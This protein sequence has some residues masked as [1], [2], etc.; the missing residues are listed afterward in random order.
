MEVALLFTDIEGSTR[1]LERNATAY[2]C[3]LARHL[4]ILRSLATEYGGREFQDA[5]DGLLLAFPAP[6]DAARAAHAMQDGLSAALWPEEIGAPRVRMAVHWAEAEFRDGQYRGAAIHAASRILGAAH[7]GQILCSEAAA[8]A[9]DGKLPLRRLGA[10]RLRGFDEALTLFQLAP[11][12]VFPPLRAKFARRHNL[13]PSQD[14]FIGRAS[15]KRDLAEAVRPGCGARLITLT[16][17]GGIGKTRLALE[18]ASE[19]LEAYEHGVLHVALSG[20]IH[21]EEIFDAILKALERDPGGEER[22]AGQVVKAL[23]GLPTLLVFDNCEQLSAEGA[24]AVGFLLKELPE[25][26][27]LATSRTQIGIPGEVD[28]SVGPLDV[29][30]EGET[31]PGEIARYETVRLFLHRTARLRVDVP[32]DADRAVC[33]ARICRALDGLPLAVELAA[34]RIQVLTVEEL[35]EELRDGGSGPGRGQGPGSRSGLRLAFDWSVRMLP[36]DAASVLGSLGVFCGGWTVRTASQVCA[37]EGA[38]HVRAYLHYLLT[39]SLIRATEHGGVMRFVMLEPIRQLCREYFPAIWQEAEG[40]HRIYFRK[41]ASRL[42]AAIGTSEESVLIDE[43]EPEI[44]NILAAIEREPSNQERLFSAVDFHEFAFNRSCNRRLRVLLTSLRQEGGE[45]QL[46]TLARA[47]NAAGALDQGVAELDAAEEAYRRAAELFQ[48]NGEEQGAM[49]ARFNMATLAFER[50][51]DQEA[52]EIF[53]ATLGVLR[54]KGAHRACIKTLLNLAITALH[55]E[56]LS[57]AH[58]FVRESRA[59][60]EEDGDTGEL[61]EVLQ[62][63]GEVEIALGDLQGAR[64]H[65]VRSFRINLRLGR[66]LVLPELLCSLARLGR[67]SLDWP[68]CAFFCGATHAASGRFQAPLSN[69]SSALMEKT[70]AV[71]RN[72]LERGIFHREFLRGESASPE[73]WLEAAEQHVGGLENDKLLD[74]VA[75]VSL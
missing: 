30:P 38:S 3:L 41:L 21:S 27:I 5:G 32:L 70:L 71:C 68:G 14:A 59:L 63:S 52:F 72:R 67:S 53:S 44:A 37:A 8:T 58:E 74:P 33:I 56:R 35:A 62:V 31:R 9:L 61:A 49:A 25:T 4:A 6:L 51:G 69:R 29:P 55:L 10:Y 23:E 16:G 19:V 64:N 34:A 40:R 42:D 50:G 60:C 18:V 1:L 57:E 15:Q 48:K 24:L 54:E 46:A 12:K 66:H 26:K 20:A 36:P 73:Q 22:L 65:F 11:E 7:G 47:W 43:V 2:A 45:V 28:I 39:C 17:P 75:A 13:P